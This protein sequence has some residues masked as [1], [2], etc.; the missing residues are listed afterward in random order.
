MDKVTYEVKAQD[1]VHNIVAKSLPYK[2]TFYDTA[3]VLMLSKPHNENITDLAFPESFDFLLNHQQAN[4]SWSTCDSEEDAILN[5]LAAT[6]SIQRRCS[7]LSPDHED[8]LA[9]LKARVSKAV[10]FLRTYMTVWEPEAGTHDTF[11]IL[12][13]ALLDMLEHE[14]TTIE[15]PGRASLMA[16]NKARFLDF[17]AQT[18][19]GTERTPMLYFLEA[20]AGLVVCEKLKKHTVSGAIMQPPA[21]TAAYLMGLAI[22]DKDSEAYLRNAIQAAGN[23]GGVPAVFPCNTLETAIVGEILHNLHRGCST[24]I[25][26]GHR[27]SN[28]EWLF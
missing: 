10:T 7:R 18:L 14:G 28:R 19:C 22:W 24:Y 26:T 17:D 8:F 1:L 6:L 5:T 25:H 21:S 16:L 3:W 11:D 12:A 4:G 15:F 23:T 13:P 9:I 20:F 2:P 27:D